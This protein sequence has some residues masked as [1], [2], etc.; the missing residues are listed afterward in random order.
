MKY[1]VESQKLV[2]MC[3]ETKTIAHDLTLRQAIKTAKAEAGNDNRIYI[4]WFR[5][6]DG[7][8][9][10]YNPDGNRSMNGMAW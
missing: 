3:V 5:K 7:Q 9:G 1:S 4:T 8:K 2:G 10:Y 6:S